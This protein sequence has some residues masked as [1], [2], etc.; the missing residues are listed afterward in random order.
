MTAFETI[1]ME[2]R[3]DLVIVVGDVNST[4]ACALTARKLGITVVHVEAGLRSGDRSM[5]EELNRLA[6]DAIC[7]YAFTSE[8]VVSSIY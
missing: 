7:D 8:P 1:C 3:P 4:L 5:P 6:T 2:N